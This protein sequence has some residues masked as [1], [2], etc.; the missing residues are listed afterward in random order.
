MYFKNMMQHFWI[1]K[2]IV[3]I[4]IQTYFQ[5]IFEMFLILETDL[6]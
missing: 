2:M 4:L 6:L 3:N 1:S 5:K